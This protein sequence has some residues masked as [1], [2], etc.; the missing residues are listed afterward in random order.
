MKMPMGM[1]S[2]NSDT[3]SHRPRF[4]KRSMSEAVSARARVSIVEDR[5]EVL[6]ARD[7]PMTAVLRCK[8]NIGP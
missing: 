5:F 3:N 6:E 7:H 4:K 8:E 1:A 2:E